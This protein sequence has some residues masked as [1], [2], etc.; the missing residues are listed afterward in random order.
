MYL[1]QSLIQNLLCRNRRIYFLLIA[2]LLV[3]WA[4]YE[5]SLRLRFDT[6]IPTD[7]RR[8]FWRTLPWILAIKLT[9][10]HLVGSLHGWW[11]YVTFSDLASLLR[12]STFA[13]CFIAAA[14]YLFSEAY[15]VPRSMLLM[16]WG[17]TIMLVGGLRSIYRLS[18]E[19]LFPAMGL[20]D[21]KPALLIGA[22]QGGEML[23]RQ[24]RNHPKL[25]FQIVGFLDEDKRNHG[26]RM[27]GIRFLGSPDDAVNIARD[28][29]AE[30]LL[31]IS[32]VLTGPRLR[33][34]VDRCREANIR[35]KMVPP[36][37]ELVSGSF[38]FQTRDVNINDLLR[39]DPVELD[40]D[41]ISKMLHGKRVMVTGA[42]GSIG[43]EICRQI[44]KSN[45]KK[46]LL[47]E[48]AEGN[49]FNI[50][51]E[52]MQ[53]PDS[54]RCIPC[55]AD[56]GNEQRMQM[57]FDAHRP[58][59]VFHAAAHKHVP[60]IE[61]NPYEALTNN[62]IATATLA[63]LC[64]ENHVERFVMI[65]TDKAV[66]PTS[67]M[68]VSKQLAERFVHADSINSDTKCVVVRFGNVLASAGS[69]VPIFQEQI[70]RGGP[71]TV[72]HP[73]MK[74]FFMTIPEASMLVL[75]A[76]AMGRGGE[77]FVLEMGEQIKIMDLVRDLIRLSGLSE[78]QI[79]IIFT[80][81]RPGEKL[82]EE[83]YSDDEQTLETP[84]PKLRVAYHRED[85]SQDLRQ[86]LE[87]LQGAGDEVIREQ[88][89]RLAVNFQYAPGSPSAE[90]DHAPVGVGASSEQ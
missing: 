87:E 66:N 86:T 16:D 43:S 37:D 26:L 52:L 30:D 32:N 82:Y 50:H 35:V 27:G 77:I 79:E 1:L 12:V 68:G 9:M 24:I 69:V 64:H 54:D 49:L 36:V 5:I 19:V 11:R 38:R 18:Q 47:V 81:V 46:L 34:L 53:R 20:R 28:L 39:R 88:L 29:D 23:A 67:I 25:D 33:E 78:D 90:P 59:I 13:S 58:E 84:H 6:V 70:R 63:R 2:H 56:V 40:T 45:P 8:D 60:L 22:L 44:L 76:S 15:Q 75:E 3:F 57:L 83:L 74:R 62:V 80:G 73:E 10:F 72:T 21:R 14:D 61:Y 71:V 85:D 31:I 7:V 55:L 51:R 17:I 41:A 4:S 42:G 89:C 48:R 65:S